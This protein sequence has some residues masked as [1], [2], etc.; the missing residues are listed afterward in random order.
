MNTVKSSFISRRKEFFFIPTFTT[1][2]CG[3]ESVC[4]GFCAQM[5]LK[6]SI[7]G[8]R[9]NRMLYQRVPHMMSFASII[10]VPQK[11]PLCGCPA[12][13]NVWT[14]LTHTP[15]LSFVHGCHVTQ[16][17]GSG[18][19][20]FSLLSV[21]GGRHSQM[22][23]FC[24]GNEAL[25]CC[26]M[27]PSSANTVYVLWYHCELLIYTACSMRFMFQIKWMRADFNI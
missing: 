20:I 25:L 8:L 27:Y 14:L 7:V 5:A 4:H 23:R 26:E 2:I 19:R 10:L 1:Q 3:C 18:Q 17:D 24:F 22:A 13:L 6:A 16:I 12:T 15:Q 11:L 9:S 21:H